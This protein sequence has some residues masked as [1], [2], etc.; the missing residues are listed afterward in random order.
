MN[1]KA[2]RG[3]IE[4]LL[5]ETNWAA[6][7]RNIVVGERMVLLTKVVGQGVL[8]MTKELSGSK[9]HLT[10][11]NSEWDEFIGGLHIGKWDD[12]VR[13]DDDDD[14]NDDD[15]TDGA[16]NNRAVFWGNEKSRLV[17][18]LKNKF[19]SSFWFYDNGTI[20]PPQIRKRAHERR[21]QERADEISQQKQVCQQQRQSTC[22]IGLDDLDTRTMP[23]SPSS[24]SLMSDVPTSTTTTTSLSST[25]ATDTGTIANTSA[26]QVLLSA[27][28]GST[29]A[30]T[31]KDQMDS[32]DR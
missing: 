29:L 2:Y 6:F 31:D 17:D 28:V 21:K 27:T 13:W 8:L 12:T 14:D 24:S 5:T 11:T 23:T 26:G 32:L 22:A 15:G 18:E 4:P 7:R 19:L 1:M 20:V 9:L 25:T 30:D 10:F 16:T 3:W